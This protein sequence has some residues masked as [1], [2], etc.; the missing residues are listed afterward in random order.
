MLFR[1]PEGRN[2]SEDLGVDRRIILKGIV[3]SE[4]L[5]GICFLPHT[6]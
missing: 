4:D 3:G 1:I 2:P 6:D 5:E